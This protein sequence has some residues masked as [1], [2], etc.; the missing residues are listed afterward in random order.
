MSALGRKV[1][2][3]EAD[4]AAIERRLHRVGRFVRLARALEAGGFYNGSKVLRAGADR[5][6]TIVA[7]P[8]AQLAHDEV[9]AE[10]DELAGIL[11]PPVTRLGSAG[12]SGSPQRPSAPTRASRSNP[13]LRHGPVA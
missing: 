13:P 1:T 3:D 12:S 5:E 2:V 6:L 10:I 9:A 8:A 11:R 7:A 4:G